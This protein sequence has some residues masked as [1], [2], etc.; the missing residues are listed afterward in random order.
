MPGPTEKAVV[1]GGVARSLSGLYRE[2][3]AGASVGAT[4][5]PSCIAAG[6]VAFG[7]LGPDYAAAGLV[8]AFIATIVGGLLTG[9]LSTSSF[10][11]S[12]PLPSLA[13][14]Q[15]SLALSLLANPVFAAKP[16]L[17]IPAMAACVLLAGLFIVSIAGTGIAGMIKYTPHPVLAGF[18]NGI[19]LTLIW[20]QLKPFLDGSFQ[21]QGLLPFL[22][23]P[24]QLM[25]LAALLL[26]V[27][28]LD[29]VT[30]TIPA[31]LLA[32][33]IG[34]LL[35]HA[36]AGWLPGF[37]FGRTLGMVQIDLPPSIPLLAAREA[38]TYAALLSVAPLIVQYAIVLSV[39]VTLQTLLA[40]RLAQSL[41][42][43]ALRPNRDL[44]AL[45]VGTSLSAVFG[46]LIISG[47]SGQ[48]ATAFRAGGRTRLVTVSMCALL[49]AFAILAPRVLALVPIIVISAVVIHTAIQTL[50]PWSVAL[51]RRAIARGKGRAS[52]LARRDWYDLAI[53]VA[54]ML[55]TAFV[56]VLPGVALGIALACF[57]FIINMSR[58]VVHRRTT[59][60][61]LTSKR[62]RSQT[63]AARLRASGDRREVI[64]LNGVLFFGNAE[65]LAD[66][67]SEKLE[68]SDVVLLDCRGVND[69][70]ASGASILRTVVERA[71][72]RKKQVLYCNV[73]VMLRP[74]FEQLAAA[75]QQPAPFA[76]LDT[77]LEW[78]EEQALS[79]ARGGDVGPAPAVSITE[80]DLVRGLTPEELGIASAQLQ[81][82]TFAA[83]ATLC[84][85]GDDGDR[86]WLLM[87]GS[88]SIRIATDDTRG[89]RRLASLAQG[90]TVGEM[91]LIED[92]KRSA[93]IVANEEVECLELS[94]AAYREILDQHP[95]IAAKLFGN[96]LRELASRIR[97]NHVD[98]RE[99]VS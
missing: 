60:A 24:W 37:D 67:I 7:P 76:D 81:P 17:V 47:A 1:A 28:G 94:K 25:A 50:D 73:P 51:A 33:I 99:T 97:D 5:L 71:R 78:M 91:A 77:A 6:V 20:L 68:R 36:A 11:V 62:V 55:V 32:I 74:R 88:V 13:V 80:H 23:H 82:R 29:R 59:G 14:V 18:K 87:K 38:S 22:A 95:A 85:Q 96:L 56:S 69:I 98:L 92:G 49:A 45:G 57:V 44:A 12:F 41:D 43:V 70:D 53:A 42:D 9:L 90:T 31:A 93:T 40:Y 2:I 63:D 75:G 10:I 34:A 30:R 65:S 83:G 4:L 21:Q 39:F 48:T 52:R 54:V 35:Y 64:E 8:A 3:A 27:F 84:S 26:L 72:K 15:G 19:S 66:E 89:T 86:M 58:P 61:S 46:G 16:A 79:K